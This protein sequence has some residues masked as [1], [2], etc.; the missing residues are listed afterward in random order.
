MKMMLSDQPAR[1]LISS[2]GLDQTLFVQAG[3]G[4]GKT[5]QLVSRIVNTVLNNDVRLSEIAAITFTEAA[6]SELQARIRVEFEK[7]AQAGNSTHRER[8]EQ[9]I[10]DTDLA[11][12][13]TVHGF[14]SRILGEFSVAAGLPPRISVLDEVA[15]QLAN[16][17]RWDRFVDLLNNEPELEELMYR[18]ALLDVPLSPAFHGQAS[19][20]DVAHN[21][22]QNWDRL[23]ELL[24]QPL[25]GVLAPINFDPFHEAVRAVSTLLDD[26]LDPGDLLAG[27]LRTIL[28]EMQAVVAIDDPHRALRRMQALHR[29]GRSAKGRRIIWGRGSGGAKKNW[30]VDPKDIKDIIDKANDALS[31]VLDKVSEGVLDQLMR[32]TAREVRQ[33]ANERKSNGGLEFHDLLVIARQVLRDS[34]E[35]RKVL[36]ERY[37]HVLL[38][39]FQDTDPIQIELASLIAATPAVRQ[40]QRWSDH[41]VAGGRLFFVG[42]PKQS[43]YRFRR[44]DIKLFLEARDTFGAASSG[45][46]RLDTNFR[47]VPPII[48]WINGLFAE[49]MP[50]EIA[51]AQPKYESLHA[52]RSLD[53]GADH[54]PVVLG[55]EHPD[56]KV[57]AGELRL[58]EATDVAGIVAA[59]RGAPDQWPVFDQRDQR[60][61]PARLSDITILIPTRTSLPFLRDALSGNDIPSRLATGT[62]VYDTQEVRDTLAVL[63]AVDDPNDT[64]SLIAAL[65]SPLYGCSDVDLYVYH[66]AHHRWSLRNAVPEGFDEQHPVVAALAHLRTM[67]EQRWWTGPASMLERVLRERRGFLLGYGTERP[68]EVWRRLR[69]LVDQAR[70]FEESNGG[71]LRAFLDWAALQSSEGSRVHEPMLPETDDE[72]VQIITVHGSKGLEFPI[73][74]LSGMTTAAKG[75]QNGVSVLWADTGPPAIKLRAGVATAE[76]TT[77]AD[78]EEEM[79]T[80]EKLRLLYVATTRARDHL[81]VSGHHKVSGNA[82]ATYATRLAMFS[83]ANPELCRSFSAAPIETRA[84]LN[85]GTENEV[86]AVAAGQAGGSMAER[87]RWIAARHGL[88]APFL[89][90]TAMS[91]TAIAR[92]VDAAMADSDDDTASATNELSGPTIVRK[93]GRAGSAIGSAVHAT[94]EFVDFDEPGDLD[95]LVQRQCELHAIADYVDTVGAL[96]RS[97][98]N[99]DA[100]ALA[101]TNTAFRELYV[102]A[103]LGD[104]MVEGY[105]DLLVQTPDGL[106]II[107][108]KTDSASS[109]AEIDAKLAAY[110][111]QGAAYAVAL[112]ESTGLN[113]VDCRFVFCKASG[114][115][116]RSV[117]DLAGAKQRVRDTVAAGFQPAPGSASGGAVSIGT[118]MQPSLFSD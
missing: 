105:V 61:R 51:D 40:P 47:T 114:A 83:A 58:G 104:V 20:K 34:A 74:I 118:N 53:S 41:S 37:R 91:A 28:P 90:P 116:E 88:L 110:E 106:V 16:E 52:G 70:A 6:A 63:R 107:D 75:K 117:V 72:A 67:W 98:L 12:V 39:E 77:R 30:A 45:E 43:I 78:L 23:D 55:G 24:D 89:I 32:L 18:A 26:C 14:A 13:S 2:A 10:A 36:H 62:L 100:V 95:A 56:P 33:A 59:I 22:A 109:R 25:G 4:T 29:R 48:D 103:P 86:P 68:A 111:L 101:R 71:G 73:T 21:F 69:F 85:V 66:Q 50:A 97:A 112:E 81:I 44:A 94:L 96:V 80:H 60:W 8:A 49:A 38:D 87:N 46:V 54:R 27:H 108:Y 76:H 115:I 15:S 35:V 57:K 84:D 102:G 7:V 5:T 9:A 65:R 113:V 79:D 93:K 64:L 92:T 17:Q 3:A 31:V 19:F 99:S 82:E 42:D 11:A 1:E